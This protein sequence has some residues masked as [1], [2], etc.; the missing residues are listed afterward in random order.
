MMQTQDGDGKQ[1]QLLTL[2]AVT[3]L[4]SFEAQPLA[5][6]EQPRPAFKCSTLYNWLSCYTALL[7]YLQNANR[8]SITVP[9][10][11]SVPS[12]DESV[13]QLTALFYCSEQACKVWSC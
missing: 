10:F 12:K 8:S 5:P 4:P 11:V 9:H 6:T 13:S 1:M 2:Q 3:W 7:L